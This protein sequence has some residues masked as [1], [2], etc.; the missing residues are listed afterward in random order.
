MTQDL[1]D[2]RNLEVSELVADEL[3]GKIGQA[4][5]DNRLLEAGGVHGDPLVGDPVQVD[6]LVIETELREVEI[7]VYNR[8]IML[9]HS[10]DDVYTRVHRVCSLID[11]EGPLPVREGRRGW[12]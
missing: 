2:P 1:A 4:I 11:Q 12:R 10:T 5:H 8:A 7:T 6:E 3:S 9:F